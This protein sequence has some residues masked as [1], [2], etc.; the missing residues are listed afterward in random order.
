M[1]TVLS[2]ENTVS[3][4]E[5]KKTGTFRPKDPV[6]AYT[7]FG[8]FIASIIAM[9]LLLIHASEHGASEGS[10]ISYTVFMMSMILLYGA[11]ASYHSFNISP[12]ANMVL[13][14][15]D[16][17]SIFALIAGSYTPIC[18]VAL[19]GQNAG[20]MLL[21]AVWIMAAAGMLFKL[22]W[23]TCPKWV[24][25][26]IYTGMGWACLMIMPQIIAALHG[27][28]FYWLLAG[29]V[30]YTIGAV[31]YSLKPA[32]FDRPGFGNHEL[33]HCFVLAGS[34][35][36]FIMMYQFIALMG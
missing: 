3:K 34:A 29:G 15:I 17:M 20:T 19:R 4:T 5:Y 24:S 11:S 26:V 21:G 7:H 2:S 22:F 32:I 18:A 14:R 16:H 1:M 23:V 33:F 36:H 35:C 9:P 31:I 6:S 25:S 28:A 12:K 10:L 13:K 8:G 30:L 27:A